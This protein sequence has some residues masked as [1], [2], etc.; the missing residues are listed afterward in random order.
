[1]WLV[2]HE[3][4][5]REQG[6]TE[7]LTHTLLILAFVCFLIYTLSSP[8]ISL[9]YLWTLLYLCI[10]PWA[11]F[12]KF[13]P[14]RWS[15]H[16]SFKHNGISHSMNNNVCVEQKEQKCWA[17]IVKMTFKR[18][19]VHLLREIISDKEPIFSRTNN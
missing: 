11:N 2:N 10:C 3:G 19:T 14:T 13:L 6:V 12:L 18:L 17:I 5:I 8:Q 7:C 4:I 16:F 1:M 15:K 9:C